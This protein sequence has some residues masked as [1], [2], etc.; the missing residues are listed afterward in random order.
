MHIQGLD[1]RLEGS[2]RE[3]TGAQEV[4]LGVAEGVGVADA[5]EAIDDDKHPAPVA[6][7]ANHLPV[8]AHAQ[9]PVPQDHLANAHSVI[10]EAD[11]VPKTPQYLNILR[12]SL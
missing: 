3:R 5:H 1:S 11:L 10:V 2:L 7:L 6:P 9:L 4:L 8:A 12:T